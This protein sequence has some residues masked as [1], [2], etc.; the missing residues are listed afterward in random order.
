MSRKDDIRRMASYIGNVAAHVA[1]Y[2]N[3]AVKEVGTYAGIASRIAEE[4]TWNKQEIG[5]FRRMAARKAAGVIRGRIGRGDLDEKEF[6]EALERAKE[7][8]DKYAEA[9]LEPKPR[10][11]RKK[12]K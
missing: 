8:I 3:G 11:P 2:P 6:D 12:S 1:V 5:G 9:E 10:K 4:R 7:Y